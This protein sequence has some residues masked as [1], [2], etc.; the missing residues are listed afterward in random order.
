MPQFK[1]SPLHSN[2]LEVVN[3]THR[4]AA[5]WKMLSGISLSLVSEIIRRPG[6]G[7]LFDLVLN[8]VFDYAAINVKSNAIRA[9]GQLVACLARAQPQK[10][11][12]KFLPSCIS[13]I[14]EELK[15]GTS[16][17][18]TTSARDLVPS[19]TT[20]HWN[21]LILCGRLAYGAHAL[22]KRK[23]DIMDLLSLLL[24]KTK[25]ER[26]YT[27]TA[28]IVTRA[29]H[30]LSGVYPS[31]NRFVNEDVR[32]QSEFGKSHNAQWSRPYEAKDVKVE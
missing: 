22:L 26:G 24:N 17:V 3:E 29:M 32:N 7:Q 8:L 13:R 11:L 18:R 4:T 2:N 28:A 25:N 23:E 21:M 31:D 19:D 6:S 27:G 20:L 14:Q 5:V 16:S 12:D 9:S 30:A 15:C 10:T 1:R